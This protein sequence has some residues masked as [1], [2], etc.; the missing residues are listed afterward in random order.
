M[1]VG[2]SWHLLTGRVISVEQEPD[3]WLLAERIRQKLSIYIGDTYACLPS[4]RGR[5]I[6]WRVLAVRG[7]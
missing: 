6:E 4:F 2:A 7:H 3:I 5:I 1:I